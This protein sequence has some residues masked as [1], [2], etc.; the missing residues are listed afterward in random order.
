MEKRGEPRSVRADNEQQEACAK[1]Q[2]LQ[3]I[4]QLR[5]ALADG[6]RPEIALRP[7]LLI[8]SRRRRRAQ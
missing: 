8:E 2:I 3:E 7:E 6:V 4:P 1:R 5:T